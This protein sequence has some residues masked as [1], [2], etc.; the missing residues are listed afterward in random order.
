MPEAMPTRRT[1]T[2]P[3]SEFEAG[4]PARPTPIPMKMY[5]IAICQYGVSSFQ[6]SS[7]P[8]NARTRNT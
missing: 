6:R 4:V 2:D 3:V 7:I 8:T 5:G 1:G